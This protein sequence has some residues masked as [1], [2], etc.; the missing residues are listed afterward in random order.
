[1]WK[2]LTTIKEKV[3]DMLTNSPKCR[4]SDTMLIANYYAFEIGAD[5]NNMTAMQLLN[6]IALK[7]VP[8]SEAI[9]RAARKIREEKPELRGKNYDLKQE[10]QKEVR[11]NIKNL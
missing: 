1:M 5:I 11:T 2:E 8:T 6:A 3:G 4:E 9:T 10:A 7:E